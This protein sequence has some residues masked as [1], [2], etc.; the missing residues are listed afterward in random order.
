MSQLCR[1]NHDMRS[2]L[3]SAHVAAQSFGRDRCQDCQRSY[4]LLTGSAFAT[5]HQRPS[6]LVLHVSGLGMTTATGCA[7][8]TAT[9]PRGHTPAY[10]R[11]CACSVASTTP[12]L[13]ATSPSTK[14]SE[15]P[16]ASRLI[17]FDASALGPVC[18]LIGHE[19]KPGATL[20]PRAAGEHPLPVYADRRGHQA[21][22]LPADAGP[23]DT[24]VSCV[25]RSARQ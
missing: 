14:L 21:D 8:S 7:Q 11:A 23:G 25:R 2:T 1:I 17:L 5:S 4:T 9:R 18:T 6:T 15:T 19:R 12:I 3:Q 13:P 24:N 20:V 22:L 16:G 10:K